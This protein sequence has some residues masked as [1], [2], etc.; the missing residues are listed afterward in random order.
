MC[1]KIQTKVRNIEKWKGKILNLEKFNEV[2]SKCGGYEV[3]FYENRDEQ[4]SKFLDSMEEIDKD[5]LMYFNQLIY[6]IR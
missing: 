5:Y 4:F 3:Y 2:D 6:R 1:Y